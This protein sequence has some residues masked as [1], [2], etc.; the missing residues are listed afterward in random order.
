MAS[1]PGPAAFFDLSKIDLSLELPLATTD[2]QIQ[3]D[4]LDEID[5]DVSAELTAA[6]LYLDDL[7]QKTSDLHFPLDTVLTFF[8]DDAAASP[9]PAL[10]DL[11][12]GQAAAD[13]A[14]SVAED[15]VPEIASAPE[16]A[17]GGL[18]A[19]GN[20]G[21]IPNGRNRQFGN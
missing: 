4:G 15:A 10:A 21:T 19:S 20:G 17:P 2:S 9:S 3:V 16:S 1:A 6:V 5:A 8:S 18:A 14:I 7:T 11:T 12:T 13:D